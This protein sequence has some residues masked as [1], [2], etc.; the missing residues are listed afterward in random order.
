MAPT[1]TSVFWWTYPSFIISS[2][3]SIAFWSLAT[4][5][6]D[7]TVAAVVSAIVGGAG[8]GGGADFPIML[9]LY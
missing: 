8:A 4:T 2:P 9:S 3:N 5:F 6:A 7:S 1:G